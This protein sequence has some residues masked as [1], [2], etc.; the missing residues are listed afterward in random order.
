MDDESDIHHI[1]SRG[2]T[3]GK[4]DVE[5]YHAMNGDDAF[6]KYISLVHKNKEPDLVLMDLKMPVMSGMEST[7]KILTKRQSANIYAF[8]ANV[9]ADMMSQVRAAGA[10]GVI[11]K[12]INFGEI[13]KQINQALK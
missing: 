5:I 8:S 10:K 6:H 12:S 4:G 7:K 13:I 11:R 2:L 9:D 1:L 3:R